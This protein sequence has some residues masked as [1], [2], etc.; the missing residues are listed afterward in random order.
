MSL[1][2]EAS[3]HRDGG[4]LLLAQTPPAADADQRATDDYQHGEGEHK[5]HA[6]SRRLSTSTSP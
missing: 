2:L 3:V 4:E 5:Y 1:Q 6:G